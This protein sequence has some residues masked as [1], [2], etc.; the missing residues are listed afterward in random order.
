MW[1]LRAAFKAALKGSHP[2]TKVGALLVKGGRVL[3]S[4]S[5]MSR[6]YGCMNRGYHAEERLLRNVDATGCILVVVRL[7]KRDKKATMSRPC[8]KCWPLVERSNVKKIVFI[9]W[10]GKVEVEK[11]A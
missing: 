7:N 1:Y 11:C 8:S 9:N 4:S 2:H 5:N 3:A 6:P 10:D